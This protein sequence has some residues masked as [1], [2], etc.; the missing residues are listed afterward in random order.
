[1]F[2]LSLDDALLHT[3]ILGS[4]K[5]EGASLLVPIESGRGGFKSLLEHESKAQSLLCIH[6]QL[7]N[8]ASYKNGG[9]TMQMPLV[10]KFLSIIGGRS[11]DEISRN[12]HPCHP[13][14]AN[15]CQ[16]GEGAQ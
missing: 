5:K 8:I 2:I 11:K 7:S 4:T 1:L 6:W 15:G 13:S 3:Q 12:S 9:R 16:C 10:S 14:F